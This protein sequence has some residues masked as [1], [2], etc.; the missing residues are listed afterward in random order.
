MGRIE[1]EIAWQAHDAAR[2]TRE[3]L[4]EARRRLLSAKVADWSELTEE[5][6]LEKLV[7][8]NVIITSQHYSESQQMQKRSSLKCSKG[9]IGI[10]RRCLEAESDE[11]PSADRPK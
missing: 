5:E 1:K 3:G 10:C 4:M 9:L 11:Y 8:R 2:K 7:Q 6:F